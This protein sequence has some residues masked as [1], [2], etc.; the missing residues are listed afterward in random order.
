MKKFLL[1][2]GAVIA[3]TGMT[4]CNG[5]S[6][7]GDSTLADSLNIT[8]GEFLGQN[9]KNQMPQIKAQFPNADEAKL[10]RGLEAAAKLDTADI[11]YAIGYSM[12]LNIII[13]AHQW[14]QNDLK[15]NPEKI[16]RYAIKSMSDTAMDIQKAYMNYQ[17][18][19]SRVQ[20][21]IRERSEAAAKAVANENEKKGEEYV[22]SLKKE[23][24][25]IQT[26]ESGLSY[27]I[28]NPG[29]VNNRPG[30]DSSVMVIY[31]GRHI[32]GEEFDSSKGQPVEFSVSGVVGGFSEGLKLLGKGGRATLYIPGKLGYGES[33]QPMAG[34]GPN[35]MLVFDVEVV[36]IL[37]AEK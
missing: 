34:I 33:G 5:S 15:T 6:S 3:M 32:N 27:K 21:M 11:S 29:D 9:I 13:Q 12:G 19:N 18:V 4:A 31:T 1:A 30:D 26:T 16:V 25:L 2:L 10:L 37:P 24:N 35:E 8:F 36:D 14:N 20:D 7:K 28:S 23:D 22:A 17:T